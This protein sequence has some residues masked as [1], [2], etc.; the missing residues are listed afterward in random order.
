MTPASHPHGQDVPK[1]LKVSPP[2]AARKGGSVVYDR[3]Y[4]GRSRCRVDL[5]LWPR[6]LPADE[7]NLHV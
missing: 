2:P 3:K 7:L 4:R 1:A 5:E 6:M